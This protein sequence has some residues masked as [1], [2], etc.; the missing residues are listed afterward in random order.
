MVKQR[1]QF[2]DRNRQIRTKNRFAK[3]VEK[4]TAGRRMHKTGAAGMPRRMPGIFVHFGKSGQRLEHRRQNKLT[5]TFGRR[6]YAAGNEIRRIF[7]YPDEVVDAFQNFRRHFRRCRPPCQQK[8]RQLLIVFAQSFQQFNDFGIV[9]VVFVVQFEQHA[10]NGRIRNQN[11]FGVVIAFRHDYPDIFRGQII[12]QFAHAA[13]GRGV[14]VQTV[15]D[16]QHPDPQRVAL[17]AFCT[18]FHKSNSFQL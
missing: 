17:Q 7:H 18:F 6:Q 3:K 15:V 16:Q 4:R 2:A 10:L 1:S 13:G 11:G 14:V 5:V 12:L 9:F 8:D